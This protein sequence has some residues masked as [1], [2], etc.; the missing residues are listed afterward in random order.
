MG[1]DTI[2]SSNN[3]GSVDV[4]FCNVNQYHVLGDYSLRLDR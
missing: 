2:G 1:Y 3:Y 4:S